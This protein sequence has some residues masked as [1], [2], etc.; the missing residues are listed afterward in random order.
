MGASQFI[1]SDQFERYLKLG[2]VAI[3][4]ALERQKNLTSPPYVFR[5]EPETTVN[6]QSVKDMKQMEE[7]YQRYLGWKAGVDKAAL[8]PENRKVLE[9]IRQKHNL[10]T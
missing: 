10:P 5:V 3:D 1:S 7:T 9:Q 6:V 4:E 8:A 2:R